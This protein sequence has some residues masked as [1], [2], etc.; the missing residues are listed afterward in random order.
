L[1]HRLLKDP[2]VSNGLDPP[3]RQ[4]SATAMSIA[5]KDLYRIFRTPEGQ[6]LVLGLIRPEMED[7][8]LAKNITIVSGRRQDEKMKTCLT[9]MLLYLHKKLFILR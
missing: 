4:R 1:H 7:H 8:R 3:D 5:D 9:Y 2:F 6:R